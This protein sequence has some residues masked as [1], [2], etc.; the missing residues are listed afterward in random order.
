MRRGGAN[1]RAAVASR[2]D[3]PSWAR[4]CLQHLIIDEVHSGADHA[5]EMAPPT[6]LRDCFEDGLIEIGKGSKVRHIE[7]LHSKTGIAY[8]DMAF[9]DNEEWNIHDVSRGLPEV[10]C[11]YTPNGMTK[12]VWEEAKAAFNLL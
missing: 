3:E 1:V 5:A 7:R 2:T 10:K 6:T 11:F 8:R 12:Q 4:I 9:F